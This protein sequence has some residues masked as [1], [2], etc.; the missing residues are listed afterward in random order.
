MKIRRYSSGTEKA[1]VVR[2]L[3]GWGLAFAALALAVTLLTQKFDRSVSTADPR[4]DLEARFTPVPSIAYE[5]KHYI[6]KARCV[7]IL[8]MGIDRSQT[9]EATGV[10]F[11]NGGQADMLLLISLDEKAKTMTAIAIDRDTMTDVTVLGVLGNHAGT[12]K[13]QVCLSHGFGDGKAQSCKL[14]C[15]AVSGLL[16]GTAIDYYAA[17]DM[18]GIP[19]LNDALGGV[20][21]T[22][23]DDFTMHDPAMFKG[24]TLT[25]HGKQ[26]EYFVRGRMEVGDGTNASRMKRQQVFMDGLSKRW[27]EKL[28]GSA[29][30]DFVGELFDALSP[31][32]VT[33]MKRG[34]MINLAWQA[35]DYA[36]QGTRQLDGEHVIGEDGF[37]EFHAE[38]S[39]LERLVIQQFY[40]P[41]ES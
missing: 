34:R 1:K 5:G 14:A 39:A 16:L 27:S 7:N 20:A 31:Y 22:L 6:K 32:L 33:D 40:T 10:Q 23:E 29:N 37:V 11:R 12:K 30:A 15:E 35:R 36:N 41:A 4:G 3:I 21:V 18:D 28:S 17:M 19:T 38:S 8:L 25:L 9:T 13:M 24:A 26:A 2:R